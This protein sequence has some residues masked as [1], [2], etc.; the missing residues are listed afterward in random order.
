MRRQGHQHPRP[1]RAAAGVHICPGRLLAVARRLGSKA[2][3][4]NSQLSLDALILT[5]AL[6]LAT[7]FLQGAGGVL[8]GAA[9]RETDTHAGNMRRCRWAGTACTATS[10]AQ[11]WLTVFPQASVA[12]AQHAAHRCAQAWHLPGIAW[13]CTLGCIVGALL[14]VS[15]PCC[16]DRLSAC[17]SAHGT[18]RRAVMPCSGCGCSMAC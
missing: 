17:G 2:R 5:P 16:N 3:W 9:A 18:C 15:N 1:A 10:L 7:L 11:A 13:H 4:A 14:S 8:G 6:V 12:Q